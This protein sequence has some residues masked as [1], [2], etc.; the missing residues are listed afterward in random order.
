MRLNFF[1]TLSLV[2]VE[3]VHSQVISWMFHP[4]N[5]ALSLEEKSIVL[6]QL[7][8]LPN[9]S[10]SHIQ[11]FTEENH[12][13]IIILA[14][15]NA[16]K[17]LYLIENKLKSSQHSNQL[18]RYK[19]FIEQDPLNRFQGMTVARFG[20]LTLLNEEANSDGWINLNY[21]N[22]SNI[23]NKIFLNK[24]IHNPD[25]VILKEYVVAL[26]YLVATI[27][28]FL[29]HPEKYRNVFEEGSLTKWEKRIKNRQAP[30]SE[31]QKY[32][33][34]NQLETPLQKLYLTQVS[35][36]VNFS[37][38]LEIGETNGVAFIQ[39]HFPTQVQFDK[40]LMQ[41]GVQFQGNSI[42]I[43]LS[44]VDYQH[45]NSSV[46]SEEIVSSFQEYLVKAKYKKL[47]KPRSKGYISISKTLPRK[48]WEYSLQEIVQIYRNEIDTA[49]KLLATIE[50]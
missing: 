13:D 22:L 26:D 38:N 36:E 49:E 11:A 2:D 32:I 27:Q 10:Y 42:K 18:S 8:H 9:K 3:R 7:F 25:Q 44:A 47:N 15:N 40:T 41:Y 16:E 33:A 19:A 4:E 43:N 39:Y 21:A 14:E 23:L 24:N 29:Q 28:D 12:I 46:I 5:E 31:R 48:L 34:N 45:S 37:A 20:Y 6:T 50:E 35:K 1:N 17:D 30:L